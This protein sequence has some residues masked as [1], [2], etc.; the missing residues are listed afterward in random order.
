MDRKLS[1]SER[2]AYALAAWL[3]GHA[4]PFASALIFGLLAH[5]YAFSNK[6]LNADET[7][8]LFSKGASVTSG[9]WGL[10]LTSYIFPDVSMPWIYGV[11]S[12]LLLALALCLTVDIFRIKS[13]LLQA[14]LGGVMLSFPAV[15]GNFCFMFTSASYALAIFLA[16]LSVYL[17]TRGGRWR[18][19]LGVALLALSLGIYQAYISLAAGYLVLCLIQSLLEA[20]DRA[21]AVLKRG[22]VYALLLLAALGLYYAV[23]F[24]VTTLGGHGYQEYEFMSEGGLVSRLIRCYSAFAGTLFFGYFG[25]VNSTLSMLM[26]L[27]LLALSL[28][29]IVLTMARDR[30]LGCCLLMALLIAIFPLSLNCMYL[31]ASV[32]IIHTLVLYSFVCVYILAAIVLDRAEG[33]LSL[34]RDAV[35]V[36]LALILAGNIFYC[37]KVYLKM[38]LQYEH[39]YAFYTTLMAQIMETPGFDENTII[40]FVGNDATGIKTMDEI[41]TALLTGPNDDLVNTYTR[42]YFMKYYLGMDFY[43]YREDTIHNA[44]WYDEMPSYPDEGS[45]LMRPEENRIIVKLDQHQGKELP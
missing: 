16:V 42:V 38:A 4:L 35:S 32:D 10:E 20:E 22:A 25:Y 45:I 41:D 5:M 37:N 13:P 21:S 31:I 17:F 9:R 8:A 43:S 36:A 44:D 3:R 28:A 34:G 19:A 1:L 15:L 2:G 40:D 18:P 24:A 7:S 11:I 12:L 30:D 27:V 39:A 6:L 14:L 29:G 26:H 33:R 23:N